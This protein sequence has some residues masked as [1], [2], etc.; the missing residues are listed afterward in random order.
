M[1]IVP[2]QENCLPLVRALAVETHDGCREEC[3][4]LSM[5]L[6]AEQKKEQTLMLE[7]IA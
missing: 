2:H 5:Q 6:P 1:R 4:D 7:E 3:R